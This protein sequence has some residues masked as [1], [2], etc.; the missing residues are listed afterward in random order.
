MKTWEARED[1]LMPGEVTG[2]KEMGKEGWWHDEP[3]KA[4]GGCWVVTLRNDDVVFV[5]V[6]L[7][8]IY[9]L[10]ACLHNLPNYFPTTC[11]H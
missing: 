6:M 8:Y 3:M 2:G 10:C 4:V 11:S 5:D 1:E 9:M 7:D